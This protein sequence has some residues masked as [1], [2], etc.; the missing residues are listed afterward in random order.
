MSLELLLN[1]PCILFSTVGFL[2]LKYLEI[3]LTYFFD[4]ARRGGS[5]GI[6][7]MVARTGL[8]IS[9]L[10]PLLEGT[11]L[12]VNF[13]EI[14]TLK[15]LVFLSVLRESHLA[16][17]TEDIKFQMA[18]PMLSKSVRSFTILPS[19]CL[20]LMYFAKKSRVVLIFLVSDV[21]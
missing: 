4:L 7:L 16:S 6:L 11:I 15:V 9:F 3:T 20:F 19:T 2:D 13:E 1:L 17:Y 18:S 8:A 12:R 5:G 14:L 10:L 21:K